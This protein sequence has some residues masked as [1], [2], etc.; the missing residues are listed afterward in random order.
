MPRKKQIVAI[1]D[2][3][4]SFGLDLADYLNKKLDGYVFKGLSLSD[5][6]SI[7]KNV[8]CIFVGLG[9]T[10]KRQEN[11][12][13]KVAEMRKRFPKAAI[14]VWSTMWGPFVPRDTLKDVIN[15]GGDGVTPKENT[16]ANDQSQAEYVLELIEKYKK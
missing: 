8:V 1:V 11:V 16:L 12:L 3:L 7:P 4:P 10:P 14:I 6:A 5:I 15:A 13:A 9:V 2:H